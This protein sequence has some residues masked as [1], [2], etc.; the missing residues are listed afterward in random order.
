MIRIRVMALGAILVAGIAGVSEAQAATPQTR[1]DRGSVERGENGR[2]HAKGDRG[3]RRQKL[4]L[5]LTEAQ[6]AQVKAIH[7]K[8]RPQMKALHERAKPFAQA[9]R[10]ARQRGDTAAVRANR[11]QMEQVMASGKT[12]RD[13]V[14]AE[15]K[16]VLTPEQRAKVEAAGN[17]WDGGKGMEVVTKVR[18]TNPKDKAKLGDWKDRDGKRGKKGKRGDNR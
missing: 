18:R 5:N 12:L 8:Y 4:D 11:A 10:D 9:A 14:H 17:R 13:Q 15:I 6:K 2:R 16:A 1:S 7:E 3:Q